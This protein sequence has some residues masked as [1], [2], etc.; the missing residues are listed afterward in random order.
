MI[1]TSCLNPAYSLF[2]EGKAEK[3]NEPIIQTCYHEII[4]YSKMFGSNHA[5]SDWV[6]LTPKKKSISWFNATFNDLITF[7]IAFY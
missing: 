6:E 2:E 4:N 7:L 3:K 1:C 5:L